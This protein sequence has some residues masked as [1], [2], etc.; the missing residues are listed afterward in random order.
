MGDGNYLSLPDFAAHGGERIGRGVC[1]LWNRTAACEQ[2]ISRRRWFV[3]RGV[4]TQAGHTDQAVA[5]P[6]HHQVQN[7]KAAVANPLR[8]AEQLGRIDLGE[9]A[10][11]MSSVARYTTFKKRSG[12]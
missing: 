1:P 7:G 5:A 10:R 3:K 12:I 4:R 8:D 11:F 6:R 9:F 2:M